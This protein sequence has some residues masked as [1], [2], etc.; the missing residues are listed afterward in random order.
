MYKQGAKY[1]MC[2]I[3]LVTQFNTLHMGIKIHVYM[4]VR[5]VK[6]WREEKVTFAPLQVANINN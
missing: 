5:G 4:H 3:L 1:V 2:R 6:Y